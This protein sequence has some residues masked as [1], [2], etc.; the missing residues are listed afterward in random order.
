MYVQCSYLNWKMN[1]KIIKK[2]SW[3]VAEKRRHAERAL[4]Y[5]L[6]LVL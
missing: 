3:A 5:R 6:F 1:E 2:K 4:E